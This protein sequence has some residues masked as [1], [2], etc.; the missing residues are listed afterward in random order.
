[1]SKKTSSL[2]IPDE[3]IMNKIILIRGQKVMID[4]D[5]AE[6]YG[7][8]TLRLNEQ[9]KRNK[10]RFPP[11]FMFQLSDKEKK[12]VI[13]NC[14]HLKGLKFSPHLPYAFTEHGAVMLASVLNSD[15]AIAVNIQIVRIFTRI[16]EMLLTHKDVLLKLNKIEKK[17]LKQDDKNKKFED[18]IQMIFQALKR[19]LNSPAPERKKI[20]YKRSS[21]EE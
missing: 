12:E 16:R 13:A 11:D 9:V 2:V 14:D 17:L 20:G 21:D 8:S 5:L 3:M 4:R 10:K 15:R 1:M 7:T 19:L 6:L 18:E